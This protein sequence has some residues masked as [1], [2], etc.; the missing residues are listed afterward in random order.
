MMSPAVQDDF[1]EIAELIEIARQKSYQAV[2]TALIE[3]YWQVGAY[4]SDKIATAQWGDAVV[5]Q[6]ADYL[7]L[8]QPN[9]KGF[10][11]SNLFRMR[12]FYETYRYD[13]KVAPLVRQLP[14]THNLII[15]SQS[16]RPFYALNTTG[17]HS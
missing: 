7:A 5:K 4:I 6:L 9:L 17:E 10:I 12:Q 13:E 14:W 11:R 15:L 3:L 8:T 1:S 2:N 16:K